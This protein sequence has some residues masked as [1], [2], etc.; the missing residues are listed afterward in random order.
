[1]SDSRAIITDGYKNISKSKTPEENIKH[2]K[3]Y[4]NNLIKPFR[5]ER[6]VYLWDET[7]IDSL[8]GKQEKTL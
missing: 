4:V 8:L 1:L 6:R 5:L 3:A 2:F 7:D